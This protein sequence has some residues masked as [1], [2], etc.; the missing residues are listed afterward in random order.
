MTGTTSSPHTITYSNTGLES[1]SVN[2]AT[3]IGT[4]SDSYILIN[5]NE[6]PQQ[7]GS[8][9]SSQLSVQFAPQTAGE[10]IAQLIFETEIGNYTIELQGIG[11]DEFIGS[12]PFVEDWSTG[13]FTHQMWSFDQEQTNWRIQTNSGNPAPTARFNFSPIATNYSFSL[14]SPRIILGAT[15]QSLVLT[16]DLKL[17]DYNNG[18]TEWIKVHMLNGEQWE[19]VASINNNGTTDWISF[20][21]NVSDYVQTESRI[22]FEATG[23]NSGF[24][25]NWEID[26]IHLTYMDWPE[27]YIEPV[28]LVQEIVDEGSAVQELYI[29]NVGTGNLSYSGEIIYLNPETGDNWLAMNPTSGTIAAQ[30]TETIEV[31]FNTNGLQVG[32]EYEALIQINSNDPQLPETVVE[33]FL[34]IILSQEEMNIFKG[35]IHP[36][37]AKE[38]LYF[39]GMKEIETIKIIQLNG[40][41]LLTY[42]TEGQDEFV[43][44]IAHLKSGSYVLQLISK[45]GIQ[46]HHQL[47]INK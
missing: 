29:S 28:E 22:R 27:I 36:N 11:F 31:N 37:P 35:K 7:L 14:V 43:L 44:N 32:N 25:A 41:A 18:G 4:N 26:N 16:F 33:V 21:Y 40:Q 38:L 15:T 24:I 10:H 30:S 45:S 6:Y 20:Q 19:E 3:I 46:N 1:F 5:Q 47:I 17:N 2:N 8:G 39:S 42:E 13:T 9:E 12:I 23:N 34:S